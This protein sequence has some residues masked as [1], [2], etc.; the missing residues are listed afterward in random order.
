M[1]TLYHSRKEKVIQVK[2]ARKALQDLEYT[3][4]VTRYN[5][6]YYICLKRD[7]LMQ[8]GREIKEQWIAELEEELNLLKVIEIN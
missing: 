1:Y 3:E 2:K 6:C 7:P 4:E 8:K 5:D